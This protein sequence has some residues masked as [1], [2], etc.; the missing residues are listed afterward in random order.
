MSHT[1]AIP[2]QAAP[3][4]KRRIFMWVFLA[5][6]A[7]FILWIAVGTGS[8]ARTC[9]GLVGQAHANCVA[10]NV[11]TGI[12]A[13]LVIVVWVVVDFLLGISYIVYKLARR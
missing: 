5:I 6:Q 12:G 10:G 11:G 13:V 4:K 1:E 3:R 9:H 8:Q 2:P 7:L